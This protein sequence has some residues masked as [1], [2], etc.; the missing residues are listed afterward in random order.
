MSNDNVTA[1]DQGSAKEITTKSVILG[2]LLAVLLAASNVYL[3]LKIGTTVA[4]SI[5]AAVVAIGVLRMFRQHSILECNIVQTAASA[6]E[7]VAAAVAFV[8]PAMIILHFWAHFHYWQTVLIMILGGLLGVA[9]SIPLRRVMLNMPILP[10][11]EGTAVGNVL[12]IATKE[13]K[14]LGLLIYGVS[15]GGLITFC[16]SGLKIFA[17]NVQ[18]WFRSGHALFGMGVGFTP[19]SMAAGY[20]VGPRVA[21]SITLGIVLSWVIGVPILSSLYPPSIHLSNYSATMSLWSH[22]I[23]YIGV[24]VMLVGGVWTLFRLLKPVFQGIKVSLAQMVKHKA[25]NQTSATE[26]DTPMIWV[27]ITT[28][29]MAVFAYLYLFHVAQHYLLQST[30]IIAWLL[31]GTLVYILIIGFLMATICAYFTG[32]VGSSNNPLSG[33]IIM[34]VLLLSLIYLAL[35]G[36]TPHHHAVNAIVLV[37]IVATIMSAVASISNENMQDLKAGQMVGSTP[38]KQQLML[39]VGVIGASLVVAPVLNLLFHA[40]GIG[41]VFP[42]PGMDPTQMLPAPQSM[43]M[44]SIAKGILTHH[45]DW[46]M[47]IVG[48]VVGVVLVVADELAR[49]GGHRLP[50]LAVGLGVYL[51]PEIMTPLVI[52][53]FTHGIIN[54][55]FKRKNYSDEEVHHRQHRGILLAC[56]LVAGSSLV[57]VVLAIP[58]VLAGSS[59][60]LAVVGVQFKPYAAIISVL[61]TF[62]LC[63]WFY[64][65][66]LNEKARL[67]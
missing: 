66:C 36:I 18:L 14:L 19:A 48:L 35:L 62:G 53:G 16:Q 21:V 41:G 15:A 38:W 28:I 12:K 49:L 23:R 32:L 20:I 34:M 63:S 65:L 61:V 8:L 50:V 47:I 9:F 57:G 39:A 37:I 52:G 51:P 45:L 64:R 1:F 25:N 54:R 24:G 59:N 67:S 33:L 2:L 4:A 11:P 6:G 29:V 22:H 13:A 55:R 10:F 3:A 40:Y 26:K 44:G 42:H 31:L 5:P 7:G 27:I 30:H 46:T 60:A 58:F 17:D 56:G 43:L